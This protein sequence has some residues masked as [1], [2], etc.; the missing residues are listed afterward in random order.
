ML[1]FIVLVTL[2]VSS[3]CAL[4][5]EMDND[6]LTEK[7]LEE[8]YAEFLSKTGHQ[9]P[10]KCWACKWAIGKIKRHISVTT[11]QR[12]IKN[13]LGHICD[14]IGFLKYLCRNLVSTYMGKLIELLSTN[15]NP[16]QICSYIKV[17][18]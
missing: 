2:L 14:E 11:N 3:V 10:G 15:A 6:V 17:C 5:R 1:R 8:I 18:W 16:A 12:A 13:M 7:E 4:Q 9:F